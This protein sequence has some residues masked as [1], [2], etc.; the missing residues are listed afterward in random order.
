MLCYDITPKTKM[1]HSNTEQRTTQHRC[2]MVKST[3]SAIRRYVKKLYR[4]KRH[5]TTKPR[6]CIFKVT[7]RPP[8]RIKLLSK[9]AT[10]PTR[11]SKEAAGYDL[12]RQDYHLWQGKIDYHIISIT[13]SY[14]YSYSSS[15]AVVIPAC[16]RLLVPTDISIGIPTGCYGR[17]A[18]RSGLAQQGIDVGAGVIDRDYTGPIRIL[19]I[20]ASKIDY[21]GM[22]K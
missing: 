13:L 7:P 20:N 12:Y 15:Q 9:E 5:K 11:G 22:F 19:V 17:I 14:N 4:V 1:Y 8:L 21:T 18:P 10:L 3:L 2:D 6:K 16:H